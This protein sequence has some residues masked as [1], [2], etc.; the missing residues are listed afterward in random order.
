MRYQLPEH[1]LVTL[2]RQCFVTPRCQ[3]LQ[4]ARTLRLASRSLCTSSGVSIH[5]K[6]VGQ[7]RGIHTHNGDP[8]SLQTPFSLIEPSNVLQNVLYTTSNGELPSSPA[9]RIA[10]LGGGITGLAS[11]HYLTREL[12][13]ARITIYEGSHRLGGWVK[14]T[15]VETDEGHVVFEQGPRSLRPNTPASYVTIDMV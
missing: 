2:L 12:P 8:S 6:T 9:P 4:R 11:A 10:V 5:S 14:S 1:T 13:H 3:G 7:R 15:R